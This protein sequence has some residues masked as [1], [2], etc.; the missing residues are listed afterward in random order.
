V[1]ADEEEDEVEWVID[2]NGVVLSSLSDNKMLCC[3][4]LDNESAPQLVLCLNHFVRS[5]F[6]DFVV[7]DDDLVLLVESRLVVVVVLPRLFSNV[8][9]IMNYELWICVL[10]YY[11]KA[12]WG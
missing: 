2:T 6:F 11:G 10:Y 5:N 12:G 8:E 4:D 9:S 7:V 1:D 3:C